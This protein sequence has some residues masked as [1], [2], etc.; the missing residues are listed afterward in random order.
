M[1]DVNISENLRAGARMHRTKIV[2]DVYNCHRRTP[3]RK[4]H[5]M[6]VI[7]FLKLKNLKRYYLGNGDFIAVHVRR[8]ILTIA[9]VVPHCLDPFSSGRKCEMLTS[10][11]Q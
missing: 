1:L 10:R 9:K 2:T 5:S 11:N 6:T 8:R 4:L 3:L 7:Y